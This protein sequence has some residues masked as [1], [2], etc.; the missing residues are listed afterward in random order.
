MRQFGLASAFALAMVASLVLSTA[1]HAE[2]PAVH[3]SGSDAD[4]AKGY[5]ETVNTTGD[6]DLVFKDDPLAAPGGFG[7]KD[8]I[9]HVPPQ[10]KRVMLLR[11]RTQFVQEMLKSVEAL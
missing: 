9:I 11:A 10:A 3:A 7:P 4:H 5:S 6:Q 1:A 8:A 2:E